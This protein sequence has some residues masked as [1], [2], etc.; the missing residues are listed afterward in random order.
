MSTDF[1]KVLV[2]DDRL[3]CSDSIRYAVQKG[4]QNITSAQFKAVSATPSSH[5]Y[6]I[7]VPSEQTI[8]DRRVLWRSKVKIRVADPAF[9]SDNITIGLTDAL[10]PFPLHQLVSVMTATINNNS[11][12]INMR[13][14]LPA[15]LRLIDDKELAR[16]NGYTPTLY[17][18]VASYGDAVAVGD[19]ANPLGVWKNSLDND[20][21][22]RGS[23][24]LDDVVYNSAGKYYD[25][26]FTVAEPLLLSPFI[27]A[28][29][30]SNNQGIYGIQNLN[31]VMNIGDATRVWRSSIATRN[32]SI[33]GFEDSELVFTFITG[34]PSDIMPARNVVPY[35]EMPRYITSNLPQLAPGAKTIARSTN[36]QLNQI[37]DKLIVYAKP[38]VLNNATPDYFLTINS[39]VVNF[40]NNSGILSSATQQDLYRMSVE[41]GSNQSWYEFSGK[42]RFSPSVGSATSNYKP[43]AGSLLVLEFGKDIQL[44]EDYY[45]SGSLGNFSLQMN[46]EVENQTGSAVDYDLYII[47]MNSG[48][49]VCERGTSSTYTGILT[50]SDVLEA[51]S[52]E[53]YTKS[54]VERLVGGG[55]LDTLKSLAVKVAPKIPSLAKSVLSNV[56]NKYAKAGAEVLGALG[57]AKPKGKLEGRLM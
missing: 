18:R 26:A 2:K 15:L 47:T 38:R 21:A 6:N 33:I 48:I 8:I 37:P 19:V 5:T 44:V 57:Y 50:K 36:L 53:A 4:G 45:C 52:Q 22:P 49:F 39:V 40:N 28:H 56:D 1:Q 12:S 42:A 10:A 32:V 30:K 14:V 35:Y 3:N 29:P 25:I 24:V 54:D 31:V 51:S 34:H 46:I 13:D 41:N 55:F 17:D 16:Y 23:W 20:L 7:Q 27:F 9:T 43:T 11:V